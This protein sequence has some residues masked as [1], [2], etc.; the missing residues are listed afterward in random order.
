MCPFWKDFCAKI[1][2]LLNSF[3]FFSFL[4]HDGF[5]AF[6]YI[7]SFQKYNALKIINHSVKSLISSHMQVSKIICKREEEEAKKRAHTKELNN[8][9]VKNVYDISIVL[10]ALK[11][12]IFSHYLSFFTPSL[13]FRFALLL[14]LLFFCL[15]NLLKLK[16]FTMSFVTLR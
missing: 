3:L 2:Y 10:G 6:T 14:R 1:E 13:S 7:W 12:L 11:L 4:S 9:L 5:L 15:Y 8:F 16:I